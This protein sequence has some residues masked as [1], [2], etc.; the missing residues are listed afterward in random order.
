MTYHDTS[1]DGTSTGTPNLYAF[2]FT[3]KNTLTV[4]SVKLPSNPN[5]EVL[6]LTLIP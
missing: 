2:S 4:Q 5:V 3:I 1:S 6:A